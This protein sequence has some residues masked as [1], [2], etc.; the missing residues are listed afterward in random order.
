MTRRRR[1][2]PSQAERQT[3]SQD[4]AY[5][6]FHAEDQEPVVNYFARSFGFAE[7]AACDEA[8]RSSALLAQGDVRV[9]VGGTWRPAPG[10]SGR[11]P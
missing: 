6:E 2:I 3:V 11:P 7:V 4:I 10:G 8:D 5:F 9:V 1:V